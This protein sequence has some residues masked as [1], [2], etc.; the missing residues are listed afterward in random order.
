[1]EQ[2]TWPQPAGNL[3]RRTENSLD[4]LILVETIVTEPSQDQFGLRKASSGT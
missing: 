1:M 3:Y 2:P 4:Y